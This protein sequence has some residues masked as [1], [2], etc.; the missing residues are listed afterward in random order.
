MKKY[1]LF[2]VYIDDKWLYD[3]ED[4]IDPIPGTDWSANFAHM[5]GFSNHEFTDL[6]RLY[7][8]F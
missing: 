6:I 4:Y 8:M 2:F 5:L 1:L 3:N 7:M